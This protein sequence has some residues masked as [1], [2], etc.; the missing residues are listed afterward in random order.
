MEETQ[1][2]KKLTELQTEKDILEQGTKAIKKRI[3]TIN[4]ETR[5][6]PIEAFVDET[7]EVIPVNKQG[8]RVVLLRLRQHPEQAFL[9]YADKRTGTYWQLRIN[10]SPSHYSICCTCCG[11]EK[12]GVKLPENKEDQDKLIEQLASAFLTELEQLCTKH[13][14]KTLLTRHA[15]QF[16]KRYKKTISGVNIVEADKYSRILIQESGANQVREAMRKIKI[17]DNRA[18]KALEGELYTTN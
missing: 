5:E 2:K 14:I 18:W 1:A 15:D 7:L 13:Q 6:L 3:E 9:V 10:D 4:I 11:I 16:E 12:R 17:N 8:D